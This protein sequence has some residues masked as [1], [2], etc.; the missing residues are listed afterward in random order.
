MEEQQYTTIRVS[1][2][3]WKKLNEMK[4][5]P[6]QTPE[7]IIWKFINDDEDLIC[8]VDNIKCPVAELGK[9]DIKNEI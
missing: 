1:V 4:S 9:E 2:E 8:P 7:D 3:L 6:K 5:S